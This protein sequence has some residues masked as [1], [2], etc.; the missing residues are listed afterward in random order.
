[1][2]FLR[3]QNFLFDIYQALKDSLFQA[4]GTAYN[5]DRI[6]QFVPPEADQSTFV[7]PLPG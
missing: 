3:I 4:K 2:E 1:M 6:P 7:I 5:L